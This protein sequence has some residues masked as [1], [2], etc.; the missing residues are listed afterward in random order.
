[1][2]KASRCEQLVVLDP[3]TKVEQQGKVD[4]NG[5]MTSQ[6]DLAKG[7][8]QVDGARSRVAD[9]GG[10]GSAIVGVLLMLALPGTRTTIKIFGIVCSLAIATAIWQGIRDYKQ[11][12]LTYRMIAC[13]LSIGVSGALLVAVLGTGSAPATSGMAQATDSRATTHGDAASGDQVGPQPTIGVASSS[14]SAD[15][16]NAVQVQGST[17]PPTVTYLTSLQPE[18]SDHLQEGAQR[19]GQLACQQS[20]AE[21]GPYDGDAGYRLNRQYRR[22]KAVF[23]APDGSSTYGARVDIFLDGGQTERTATAGHP[24]TID[25]DVST[26]GLLNIEFHSDFWPTVLCDA[27]LES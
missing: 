18:T 23:I 26:V 14:G 17:R 1:V 2:S 7:D 12:K 15:Q 11:G 22:F 3:A 13:L 24:V 9:F 27:R 5:A 10:L 16:Q 6:P 21:L 8:Q 4:D 25:L 19:M 20:L